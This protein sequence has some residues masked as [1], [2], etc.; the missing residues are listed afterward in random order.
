MPIPFIVITYFIMLFETCML[1]K[2]CF[3]LKVVF[4]VAWKSSEKN[5]LL[6]Y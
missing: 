6:G 1:Q 2:G 5:P 4:M 3:K